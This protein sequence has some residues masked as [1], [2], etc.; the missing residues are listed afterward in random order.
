MDAGDV[1]L[2]AGAAGEKVQAS[3]VSAKQLAAAAEA[4]AEQA[5]VAPRLDAGATPD[6]LCTSS[7]RKI[8]TA[9]S[10]RR[11]QCLQLTLALTL[12]VTITQP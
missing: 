10:E 7:S 12:S 8:D 3:F 1:Q 5:S 2:A 11:C 6:R 9:V 4:A